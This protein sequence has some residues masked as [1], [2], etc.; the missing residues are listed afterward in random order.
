MYIAKQPKGKGICWFPT[1][2]FLLHESNIE[3]NEIEINNVAKQLIHSI[4]VLYHSRNLNKID[5][6]RKLSTNYPLT[7]IEHQYIVLKA[8]EHCDWKTKDFYDK[9][10]TTETSL[11]H[12]LKSL[13]VTCSRI[14]WYEDKTCFKNIIKNSSLC[15]VSYY[16][17]SVDEYLDTALRY[18][19]LLPNT[20]ELTIYNTH[21][22]HSI[23]L[24][25]QNNK[26]ILLDCNYGKGVYINEL[27]TSEFS[28][29]LFRLLHIKQYFSGSI[30]YYNNC[31]IKGVCFISSNVF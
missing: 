13:N 8:I 6:R 18:D 7:N 4:N 28:S 12:V 9:P 26:W 10:M 25:K 3:F 31:T 11:M 2:V 29:S 22:L 17:R 30:L 21:E 23:I 16:F 5:F 24:K 20:F 27:N 1:I 15:I 14:C 19:L